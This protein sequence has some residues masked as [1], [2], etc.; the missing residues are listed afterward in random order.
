[1]KGRKR[2]LGGDVVALT[3]FFNQSIPRYLVCIMVISKNAVWPLKAEFKDT[4]RPAIA[5][6]QLAP[7]RRSSENENPSKWGAFKR[8]E[9]G[10]T[11]KKKR[12]NF[13]K[14]ERK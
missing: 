3:S 4:S 14:D 2:E 11:R 9:I 7:P 8:K 10:N 6:R 1:M 5:K 12:K 13:K